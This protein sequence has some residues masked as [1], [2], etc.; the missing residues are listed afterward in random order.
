MATF[1]LILG[2]A[3]F[4][5]LVLLAWQRGRQRIIRAN[6]IRAEQKEKAKA[7]ILKIL[8]KK[9]KITNDDVENLLGISNTSAWR[10]LDEL[11]KEGKIKQVGRTG[12]SV[13]Y[14]LK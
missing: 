3:I 11:E 14:Q 1:I 8:A 9:K 2:L 6:L 4:I 13:Y 7:M 10:Y 5:L 12:R